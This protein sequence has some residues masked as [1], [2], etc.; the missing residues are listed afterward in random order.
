MNW[1]RARPLARR[2]KSAA[3]ATGSTALHLLAAM[4]QGRLTSIDFA[5][6]DHDR[7]G[8][9]VIAAAGWSARHEL[10]ERN[11]IDVLPEL[12][13]SGE[14][15]DVIFLDGWKTIDHLWVDTFYCAKLL[16]VGGVMVFDDA[17]MASTLKAVKL[18]KSH[19]RFEE[20]DIY[21]E[22]GGRRLKMWHLLTTRSF[23]PPTRAL[24]KTIPIEQS[25]AGLQYD[26][27]PGW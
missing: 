12:Y 8:E 4:P 19:Y 11:S 6:V 17:R 22:V 15:Y 10:I 21:R 7:T 25:P 5:H 27:D 3:R 14:Q 23:N 20:I 24:R 16:R 13:R 18:L 26:F 2:S 1:P 9:K